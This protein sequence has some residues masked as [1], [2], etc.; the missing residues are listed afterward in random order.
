MGNDMNPNYC[1]QCG[2]PVPAGARFC[3]ACGHGPFAPPR[4]V[5]DRWP[6]PPQPEPAPWVRVT[7]RAACVVLIC[8]VCYDLIG[9]LLDLVSSHEFYAND[10]VRGLGLV[11]G[12]AYFVA[13]SCQLA[14]L[15]AYERQKAVRAAVLAL[16]GGYFL[17]RLAGYAVS[18]SES[19]SFEYG[20]DEL[21]F[22]NALSITGLLVLAAAFALA[23]IGQT[24]LK[25]VGSWL[26]FAATLA[27]LVVVAFFMLT[28]LR[29]GGYGDWYKI[30]DVVYTML[31]PL[32]LLATLAALILFLRKPRA[33]GR[34]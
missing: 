28:C 14:C 27:S 31:Q 1:P 15:A 23:S 3:P 17:L 30:Y 29:D 34:N 4:P 26:Y 10:F 11:V 18:L 19:G 16:A 33:G 2:R 13:L 32:S 21:L 6:A 9:W 24:S 25:R 7:F 5:V 20:S 12:P 8:I 22:S